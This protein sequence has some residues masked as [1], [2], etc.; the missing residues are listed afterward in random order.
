MGQKT[1]FSKSDPG[2]DGMLKEV[3]LAHFGPVGTR[4]GPWI[5]PK[6]LEKRPFWDQKWVKMGFC[7]ARHIP[8]PLVVNLV[9][10]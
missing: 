2:L 5:I 6:C 10:T 8:S 3:F 4:F 9:L 1:C 7:N